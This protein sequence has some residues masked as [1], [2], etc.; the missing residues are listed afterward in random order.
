[1][2]SAS[3]YLKTSIQRKEVKSKSQPTGIV[4]VKVRNILVQKALV[5]RLVPMP[6]NTVNRRH[7][8][9]LY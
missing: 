9:L 3:S 5:L 4:K 8:V 2:N 7:V 1:M 6:N